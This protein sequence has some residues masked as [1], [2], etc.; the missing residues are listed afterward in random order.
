MSTSTMMV[1]N[2]NY[3]LRTLLGHTI[4]F[5][6]NI[7][8]H[9]PPNIRSQA[10]AIGAVLADGSDPDVLPDELQVNSAPHDLVDRVAAVREAIETIVRRNERL[11]FTAAGI[12]T[13]AAVAQ[14]T[15]WKVQAREIAEEWQARGERAVEASLQARQDADD[16]Q[17]AST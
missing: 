9:V 4:E 3:T 1:L 15:G 12:P 8:T 6:R 11:D 17:K 5:R 2:R 16:A 13:V 10:I 14:V 7:P